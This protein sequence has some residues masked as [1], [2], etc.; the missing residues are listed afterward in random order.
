M[1]NGRGDP[2]K[3]KGYIIK[4][5]CDDTKSDFNS[6]LRMKHKQFENQYKKSCLVEIDG[7][8]TTSMTCKII[9]DGSGEDTE[10]KL[11]H[12]DE[13]YTRVPKLHEVEHLL[14]SDSSYRPDLIIF[15]TGDIPA[16]DIEKNR[17][18]VIQRND[19]NIRKENHT[20]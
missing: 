9:S 15:K 1:W 18:E 19:K 20:K 14:P 4:Y 17:L 7:Q 3:L 12:I 11:W 10:I 2:N 16:A 13:D 6:L 5:D 8:W